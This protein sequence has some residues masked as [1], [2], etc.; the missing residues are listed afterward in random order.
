MGQEETLPVELNVIREM[1]QYC[2][3][4]YEPKKAYWEKDEITSD[5]TVGYFSTLAV[6]IKD[7]DGTSVL[8][9]R[10]TTNAINVVSD[11]DAR[12]FKDDALGIYV[13][14][15]FRDAAE[16]IYTDIKKHYKLNHIVYLT[17]HSLGGAIAQVIGLWLDE[18]GYE[19]QIYTFGTPK[20]STTFL[21]RKPAHWRVVLSN[22]PVPYLPPWPYV[23]SGIMINANTLEWAE[24]GETHR[25]SFTEIDGQDH[26]I[27]GYLDILDEKE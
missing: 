19:V 2:N 22:D 3:E 7:M 6:Q 10:G 12:T 23:H 18:E 20:I 5:Y 26:S 4:M 16:I 13:H 15:G 9:F 11:L 27:Q 14:R 25:D 24:G 8:V 17:G 1:A 21:G